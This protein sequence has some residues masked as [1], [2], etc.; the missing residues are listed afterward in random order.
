MWRKFSIPLLATLLISGSSFANSL[1][2]VDQ[3]I[4]GDTIILDGNEYVRLIGINTPET[5]HPK[6][7]VQCYGKEASDYLKQRLEGKDVRLEYGSERLDKYNRTLGFI[8][9]GRTFINA[10]MVKEG[11]A[12]AYTRFPFKYEKKF[13][14][15]QKKA[16]KKDLGLWHSCEVTCEDVCN[17]NPRNKE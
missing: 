4:D 5:H 11:Y 14:K 12:F 17:T 13:V 9:L 8:H 6:K 10:E 16:E 7:P 3:V 2:H 15:L 1:R